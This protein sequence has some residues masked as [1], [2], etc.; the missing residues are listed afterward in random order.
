MRLLP[1]GGACLALAFLATASRAVLAAPVFDPSNFDTTCAPCRDFDQYAN[2]GWKARTKMPAAYARF[3]SFTDLAD[4][5]QAILLRIMQHAATAKAAPRSA[6]ADLGAYRSSR[7]GS[8]ADAARAAKRA[9]DVMASE[10]AL[11]LASMTNVQRR[12]P[13]ATYHL[14]A[15]DTMMVL[16]PSL[17]WNDYFAARGHRPAEVNVRQ[18]D[19][20]RGMDGLLKN[21]PLAAWKSYLRWK[22]MSDAEGTLNQAFVDEDFRFRKLLTGAQE[23]QPRWRRCLGDADRDVG[24]LLGKAFVDE[25]F[26]PQARQ[27]ALTL[28]HNL[29]AALHDK[30]SG[31]ACMGDATRQTANAKPAAF[32]ENMGSPSN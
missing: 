24:E 19:F 17:A 1:R 20:L 23:M 5:N 25:R 30:I 9:A 31:L 12:D 16:C 10:K 27:R 4:R 26:S 3:G 32:D 13:Q 29:E 18:P 15:T 14:M 11:A 21:V 7:M 28:V 22:V 2:G 8:A 6:D